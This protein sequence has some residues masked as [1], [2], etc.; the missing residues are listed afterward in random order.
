MTNVSDNLATNYRFADLTLDMLR[1]SVA[2]GG[3]PIELKALDFDLLRFLVEQ[4]PN[5]VNADVLAE[6]VWGRHFVSPENVAQRVMLLR[7]SLADDAAKP[8]YIETVRNKGYRLIP[9]VERV[10]MEDSRRSPRRGWALPAIGAGLLASLGFMVTAAYWLAGSAEQPAP[11]PTSI[12]VLPFENLSPNADDAFFAAGMQD[13]IVSQLTKLSGLHVIPVRPSTGAP[14]SIPEIVRGLNVAT[15]LG[16]GVY[17]WEGRVRITPRLTHAV[18]GVALWADT[19]ERERHDIFAIQSEIALEV[20][21]ALSIELSLAER[22]RVERPPTTNTQALDYY[23]NAKRRHD[24]VSREEMR[25]ATAELEQALSLDPKFTDAWVLSSVI[26]TS[27]LFLDPERIDEHRAAARRSAEQALALDPKLAAA[28]TALARSLLTTKDWVAAESAFAE[29]M[30]LGTSIDVVGNYAFLR[31]SA[32]KFEAFARDAF[33]QVRAADHQAEVPHRF[34]AFVHAQMGDWDRANAVYE[35]ALRLFARDERAVRALQEQR[36]H[37][38][39]GRGD[40]DEAGAAAIRDPFNAKMLARL[41]GPPAEALAE[42]RLAFEASADDN[43]NRRRDIALWAGHFGDAPLALAAIRKVVDAQPAQMAYVW[44][45]QLAVMRRLP[46]FKTYIRE[47]G[48]VA[49]W[50]KYGWPPFCQETDEHD[51]E[52]T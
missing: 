21:R 13:E 34:L 37:W 40:L 15:T 11:N 31:M 8:R 14:G 22:T 1:R 2:R 41:D 29:A 42:L 51:F 52:C 47:I 28:H 17:Y 19:Y 30:R 43:P 32:G 16:G 33:E 25:L 5:V 9:V 4:A 12:A 36:M 27:A 10:P 44:L 35:S 49:Y 20:A 7:Q 24:R 45:P 38:L 3:Q 6:K 18:T 46:E 26:H 48:M 39:V 50:Q 23:L